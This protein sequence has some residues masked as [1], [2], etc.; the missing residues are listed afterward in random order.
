MVPG[1]KNE[2]RYKPFVIAAKSK[3]TVK[4]YIVI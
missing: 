3:M 2:N 4:I 1:D